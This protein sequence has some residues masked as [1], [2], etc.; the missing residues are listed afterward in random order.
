MRPSLTERKQ[1]E[2]LYL[3]TVEETDKAEASPSKSS[4][5]RNQLERSLGSPEMP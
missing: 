2:E 1:K 3:Q 4:A 5:L